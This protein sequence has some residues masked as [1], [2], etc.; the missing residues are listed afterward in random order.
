MVHSY[1]DKVRLLARSLLLALGLTALFLSSFL[2][3][4]LVGTQDFLGHWI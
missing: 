2:L 1:F 4:F 3:G